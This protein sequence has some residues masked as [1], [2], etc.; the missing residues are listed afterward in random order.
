MEFGAKG[1]RD[2]VVSGPGVALDAV[3]AALAF[4][5]RWRPLLV[6]ADVPRC[7][8]ASTP[9]HRWEPARRPRERYPSSRLL[10]V[11]LLMS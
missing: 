10:R 3:D 8:D 11:Q 7:P 4:R 5:T 9:P 1:G 6:F 2:A